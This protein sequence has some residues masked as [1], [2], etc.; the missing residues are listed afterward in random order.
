MAQSVIRAGT[1]AALST[2]FNARYNDGINRR[3]Q[4][5]FWP[6]LANKVPS[7]TRIGIYPFLADIGG[8]KEWVGPRVVQ[9]LSTRSQQLV[10]K[11]YEATLS[12]PRN[13]ILDDQY[14]IYG[15]RMSLLGYQAE[16]LPDDLM[17]A[18]LQGGTTATGLTYDSQP[19]F[20][21][22][23]P[24][25]IDS[26]GGATQSN[27]FTTTPLT[28]ANY[29]AVRQAMRLYRTD[30]GRIMGYLPDLI[31]VP[32][33]LEKA[34]RDIVSSNLIAVTQ[35]SG[36]AAIQNTLGGTADVLVIPELGL[37][38]ATW[39]LAVTK[40]PVKPLIWQ[41][42]QAPQM[43]ALADPAVTDNMFWNKEYVWGVDARGAAGY[44]MWFLMARATA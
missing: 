15:D 21:S 2:S 34:A 11:D 3:R 39:Y 31:I 16:K 9:Q 4:E 20:S 22:S 44:A 10:N 27:N 41:E 36:A 13:D 43:Q 25:N 24:V 32:P 23:H 33:Q 8:M 17:V 18:V 38:P 35:G 12:V 37:D 29:D 19:F 42:R 6:R 5:L 1:L 30:S 40:M 14:G 26:T 28:P 7:S